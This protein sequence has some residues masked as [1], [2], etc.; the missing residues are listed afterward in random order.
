MDGKTFCLFAV[1]SSTCISC[2][3]M[4]DH[5][6]H[7]QLPDSATSIAPSATEAGDAIAALPIRQPG[8]EV[9]GSRISVPSHVAAGDILKGQAPSGS[10]IEAFGQR[11]QAGN[12]GRFQLL[13][14]ASPGIYPLRIHRPSHK[15]PLLLRIDVTSVAK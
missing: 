10:V 2:T 5:M 9:T 11:I 12:D 3:H 6:R 7:I 4:D 14:P 1:I 15:T 13:A 8:S